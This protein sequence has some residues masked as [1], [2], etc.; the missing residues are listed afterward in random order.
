MTL[1]MTGRNSEK[2]IKNERMTYDSTYIYINIEIEKDTYTYIYIYIYEL[3]KVGSLGSLNKIKWLQNS[4][5][6]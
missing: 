6:S 4:V 2:P 5:E 1:P 3:T